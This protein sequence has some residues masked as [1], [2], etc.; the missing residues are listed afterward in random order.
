M[1]EID[2]TNQRC[3]I[4][5]MERHGSAL[6]KKVTELEAEVSALKEAARGATRV[7]KR[8]NGTGYEGCDVNGGYYCDACKG[9]G[10]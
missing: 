3:L 9:K 4:D 8:C 7:C 10:Y 6:E 1:S 5:S 2:I